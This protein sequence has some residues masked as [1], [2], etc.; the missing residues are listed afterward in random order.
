M[1]D[2]G[3]RA[4]LHV[5]YSTLYA[6][7]CFSFYIPIKQNRQQHP[8]SWFV[9]F[10]YLYISC[11]NAYMCNIMICKRA[12]RYICCISWQERSVYISSLHIIRKHCA[13]FAVVL[14]LFSIWI[15]VLFKR[16][17][18]YY[19]IYQKQLLTLHLYL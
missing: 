8:A 16:S 10:R 14:W 3:N 17:I 6:N 7:I 19:N 15:I 13:D 5:I 18:L 12:L 2:F 4:C 11:M 1:G 9:V